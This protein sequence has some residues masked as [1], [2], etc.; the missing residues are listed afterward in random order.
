MRQWFTKQIACAHSVVDCNYMTVLDFSCATLADCRR[1]DKRNQRIYKTRL[2]MIRRSKGTVIPVASV[3]PPHVSNEARF[4]QW[5]RENTPVRADLQTI[6]VETLCAKGY[7]LQA[8]SPHSAIG[9]A[10]ASITDLPCQFYQPYGGNAQGF[11]VYTLQE[12]ETKSLKECS[13]ADAWNT[14]RFARLS[15]TSIKTRSRLSSATWAHT[16]HAPQPPPLNAHRKTLL[17]ERQAPVS[18]TLQATAVETLYKHGKRAGVDY[19]P[20]HAI[21]EATAYMNP[22]PNAPPLYPLMDDEESYMV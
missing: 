1:A 17:L 15:R 19:E 22:T 13:K 7:S 20:Q 9:M 21:R 8:Y 2:K 11:I 18:A 10:K 3:T 5:Q 4:N 14:V 16:A 6:A 12:L